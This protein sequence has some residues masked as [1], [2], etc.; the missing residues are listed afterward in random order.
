MLQV[1]AVSHPHG[2]EIVGMELLPR[3]SAAEPEDATDGRCLL[4][5]GLLVSRTGEHWDSPSLPG[6]GCSFHHVVLAVGFSPA[7]FWAACRH[8]GLTVQLG[9]VSP[10]VGPLGAGAAAA[11]THWG[12]MVWPQGRSAT[13]C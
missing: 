3:S 5:L 4:V 12:T 11:L 10:S 7:V 13:G 1:G 2:M 8:F 6:S 9:A